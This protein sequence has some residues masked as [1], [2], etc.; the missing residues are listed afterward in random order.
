MGDHSITDSSKTL[1]DVV[2]GVNKSSIAPIIDKP[3]AV[4]PA[5]SVMSSIRHQPLQPSIVTPHTSN[6]DADVVAPVSSTVSVTRGR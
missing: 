3:H 6:C 4:G 1:S 2:K 5:P